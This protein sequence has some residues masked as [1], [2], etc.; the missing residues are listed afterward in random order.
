MNGLKVKEKGLR[1]GSWEREKTRE[2]IHFSLSRCHH[3]SPKGKK[4]DSKGWRD[5][6]KRKKKEAK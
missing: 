5:G 1:K 6:E 3:S 2:G 4:R